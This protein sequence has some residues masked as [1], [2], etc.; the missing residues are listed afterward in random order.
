MKHIEGQF[1]KKKELPTKSAL[2]VMVFEY[3]TTT[4]QADEIATFLN[5]RASDGWE[6][7]TNTWDETDANNPK[8]RVV[9]RR[10]VSIRMRA[11]PI[12]YDTAVPP[13][14]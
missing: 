12:A 2:Q 1:G 9:I 10:P 5:E 8:W 14:G 3:E 13:L 4:V 11:I 7:L 6:V